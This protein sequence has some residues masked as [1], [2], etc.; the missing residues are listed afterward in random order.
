MC[1]AN[2][3]NGGHAN[4]YIFT[5]IYIF[6]LPKSYKSAWILKFVFDGTPPVL[7][8]VKSVSSTQTEILL[9]WN[10]IHIL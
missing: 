9:S 7:Y 10:T 8:N 1:L 4:D 2:A 3:Q 5:C 6:V